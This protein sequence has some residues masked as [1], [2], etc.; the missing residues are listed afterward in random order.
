MHAGVSENYEIGEVLEITVLKNSKLSEETISNVKMQLVEME[1]EKQ[2]KETD[3]PNSI[4]AQ[5]VS[6]LQKF[7]N[8]MKEYLKST[9]IKELSGEVPLMVRG[10]LK[11]AKNKINELRNRTNAALNG[12]IDLPDNEDISFRFLK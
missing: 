12:K 5:A 2:V 6:Q 11:F 8:K 10:M 7:A 4:S 3:V 9:Q 1:K